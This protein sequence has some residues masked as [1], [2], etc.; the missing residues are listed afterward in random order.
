MKFELSGTLI[1]G[2]TTLQSRK[3]RSKS[4]RNINNV[5][6]LPVTAPTVT[7][8]SILLLHCNEL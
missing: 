4:D 7:Y 6:F 2:V 1:D 3:E 5:H 8:C